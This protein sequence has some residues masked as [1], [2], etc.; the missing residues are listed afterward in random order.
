MAD[1]E[2]DI[3]TENDNASQAVA[4]KENLKE[5]FTLEGAISVKLSKDVLI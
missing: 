4:D 2:R 5:C 1:T 3:V